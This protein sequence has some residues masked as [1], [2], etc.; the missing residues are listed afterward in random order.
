[1]SSTRTSARA[2]LGPTPSAERQRL[3]DVLRGLAL[4]GILVVNMELFSAPLTDGWS[5][6]DAPAD[7][8]AEGFVIAF[9]Q[10]K[11]YLLFSLLFGYGLALQMDRARSA[12]ANLRPRY[13]R[14]MVGL[15]VIGLLHAVLLFSGDILVTYALL[16]L[17]L[18]T[19]RGKDDRALLLR[20]AIIF[21]AG[22]ALLT[23][24]VVASSVAGDGTSIQDA[25][26]VRAAYAEGSFGEIIAQRLRDLGLIAAFLPFGQWPGTMAAF[27]VGLVAGRR[28]LLA[29]P[30][31][32]VRLYRRGLAWGLPVGLIGGLT[33][34]AV[35]VR[36][37]G[38]TP[39]NL[40]FILQIATA[41]ALSIA[42]A[43]A[44]GLLFTRVRSASVWDLAAAAGRGSL[45]VYLAQSVLAGLV[46]L[47]YG[48][49]LFGEL[50]PA[51]TTPIAI[52]IWLILAFAARWWF[53]RYRQGPAEWF[54]RW[55]TY[56]TRPDLRHE[57]AP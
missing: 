30:A 49:G 51:T 3:V 24:I 16:G 11:F 18:F 7:R 8:L 37:P 55:V 56:G 27:L 44:L 35:A 47:S 22:V 13:Q 15:L 6:F 50:G 26:A 23:A 54:L 25:D 19:F 2:A 36:Q 41:P 10:G 42:Y 1:M 29:D 20:A 46:F 14:R 31:G 52:A 48:L 21:V 34:G 5:T 39:E 40:A 38:T 32:H 45:S 9:A 33:A 12:G 57:A 43:C 28:G 53:A 17:L 4:L